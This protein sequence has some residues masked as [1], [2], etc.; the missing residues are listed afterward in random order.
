MTPPV[1][2]AG[3]PN[4]S[5]PVTVW[6]VLRRVVATLRERPRWLLPFALAGLV[7]AA[8]DWLRR[9]DPLP[10]YQTPALQKTVSVQ[11]ALFPAG[12]AQ[13]GRTVDALV[14][15]RL[16]YLLGAVALELA[17]LLAVAGAGYLTLARVLDTDRRAG[18]G[19]RYGAVV[20]V[21]QFLPVW[22]GPVDITV[23]NLLVGLVAIGLFSVVAV[24]LYL[25]PGLVVAGRPVWTALAESRRRSFG[26][27]WSLFGLIVVFGL[28]SWALA[29]VPVV[30]G[31][32]STALVAPAQAVSIG[33]MLRR[34][35][36]LAAGG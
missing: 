7:V 1:D 14:N 34:T 30:G 21:V 27:G 2:R 35:G 11:Y 16:R 31:F 12:T 17:V 22:L 4:P 10:A 13:T 29:L 33:V 24:R 8:A 19:Y 25:L 5:G 36:P 3:R 28:G 15:L 26:V 6:R 18:A 32:L 20:S 9:T 23:G